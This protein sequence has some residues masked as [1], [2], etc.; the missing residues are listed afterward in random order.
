MPTVSEDWKALLETARAMEPLLPALDRAAG[1][2]VGCLEAGGRVL[3]CGNGGSAT[4]ACHLAEEL[5]GR[6]RSNR[7]SLPGISL[8]ADG[9]V[10]TCIGNDFGFDA[11][12]SR[13][14]EGLGRPG[15]MLV[16]F[17]SSGHSPN[18]LAALR[19]ARAGKLATVALLGKDGG[20][21]RGQADHELIVPS[22]STARIQEMHTWMMHVLLERV[23]ARFADR[24]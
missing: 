5:T 4:D 14:V 23:E 16:V 10:L 9:S 7:R 2:M 8:S 19:S 11:V 24:G 15:D 1:A 17:S 20:P 13:Q 22:S 21:C 6:Y 3:T 12:F 18:I